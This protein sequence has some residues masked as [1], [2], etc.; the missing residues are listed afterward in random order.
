MKKLAFLVFFAS[1]IVLGCTTQ[2]SNNMLLIKG[3]TFLMGSPVNDLGRKNDETQHK[4]TV[5]SFYMSIFPVTQKEY[6]EIMETNP[7]RFEGDNL[8]VEKVSWYD[9]IEYC[10]RMSEREGLTPVYM[11]NKDQRDPNNLNI[12]SNHNNYNYNPDSLQWNVIWNRN[13]NGYRLPTEAEWEYACRAGTTTRYWCGDDE[14]S[15]LGN[16]NAADLTFI[17]RMDKDDFEW[18]NFDDGHVSTSP[19]GSFAPN[20]WGLYDMHGNVY[21]WCWDWY[22]NYSN[23]AQTDPTGAVSGTD[24][25]VRGGSWISG[26]Q[27]LRSAS[28]GSLTP[29]LPLHLFSIFGFRVV[30]NP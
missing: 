10:N 13:A 2:H 27:E 7:S 15:L 3:G 29:S 30:R 12:E 22:D 23:E 19:V 6:M 28:R 11:I 4:V 9:A 16:I 17:E 25:V 14:I 1:S 5:N 18:L 21:E 8:P 26:G 20:P 24:R